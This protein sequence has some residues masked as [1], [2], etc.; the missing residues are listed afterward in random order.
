MKVT[1]THSPPTSV[2]NVFEPF[3]G[4]STSTELPGSGSSAAKHPPT[5]KA[6][7]NSNSQL[8]KNR[9]IEKLCK[10]FAHLWAGHTYWT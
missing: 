5:S 3:I 7:T 10:A 6:I 9:T 4:P 8:L 1:P 2:E